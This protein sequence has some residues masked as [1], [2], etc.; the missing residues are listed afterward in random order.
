M[1]R[2]PLT[3]PL[4]WA[5]P[6][7][8]LAGIVAAAWFLR[9]LTVDVDGVSVPCSDLLVPLNRVPDPCGAALRTRIVVTGLILLVGGLPLLVVAV[10]ACV[11]A[12]DTLH[13][14]RQDVRRLHERLDLERPG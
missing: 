14:L 13:A 5:I 7:A 9:P 6:L 8:V 10:R 2:S 3:R 4:R 12:A 1:F 11:L